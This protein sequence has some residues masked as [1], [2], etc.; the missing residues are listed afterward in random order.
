MVV[1]VFFAILNCN[2]KFDQLADKEY[3]LL[4]NPVIY[5]AGDS[6]AFWQLKPDTASKYLQFDKSKIVNIARAAGHP[7]EIENLIRN[8]RDK[9]AESTVIISVSAYLAN[10]SAKTPFHYSMD[11]IGRKNVFE[12]I[13]LFSP[14]NLLTLQK[15]YHHVFIGVFIRPMKKSYVST[16]GYLP[17]NRSMDYDEMTYDKIS[18]NP[19]YSNYYIDKGVVNSVEK[20]FKSIKNMCK[21]LIVYNAPF[22]RTFLKIFKETDLYEIENKFDTEMKRICDI[23]G[24][25]YVSYFNNIDLNDEYFVDWAHLNE[26]GSELFTIKLLKDCYSDMVIP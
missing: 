11:L 7:V 8:N 22:S 12:Q 20:S 1:I 21:T 5:F 24:I 25:K 10:G 4:N 15:Y 19:W 23:N 17:L 6:R 16:N 26:K 2:Y 13:L 18:N 3:L 14:D 9:F